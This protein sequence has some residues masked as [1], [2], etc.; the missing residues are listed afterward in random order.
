[1]NYNLLQHSNYSYNHMNFENSNVF[2]DYNCVE[3]DYAR[4]NLNDQISSNIDE[5]FYKLRLQTER[6][7][8]EEYLSLMLH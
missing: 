4:H 3:N 2:N 1:M 7:H 5:F 6:I 8:L